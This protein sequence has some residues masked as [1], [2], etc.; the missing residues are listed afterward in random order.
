[1]AQQ[2]T[3]LDE[4]VYNGGDTKSN[5]G[6][7]I[8]PAVLA[9]QGWLYKAYF[10]L[11][12]KYKYALQGVTMWGMADD[13][14][15]LDSFPVSRTDYPLPF[16]MHLQA[17]PAYWGIVNPT[18]LPGYGMTFSLSRNNL[19]LTTQ[20]WTITAT[21]GDVGPA[22]T[23]Q[24]DSFTLKQVAG[25]PCS[26]MVTPPSSYP[27]SLGDI[28]TSGSADAAFTINFTGCT[29]MA[30]FVAQVPWSSAVYDTGTFTSTPQ[31]VPGP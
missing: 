5:Y 30:R 19:W 27:V 31:T 21:N 10:D 3:E 17:K 23:T 2:V 1:M 22:Y 20:T 9:E 8:P 18:H 7:N 15:W 29:P 14:T 4:S 6:N 13:D 28:P 11:F 12:R 16:D 26:P 25:P 24:L